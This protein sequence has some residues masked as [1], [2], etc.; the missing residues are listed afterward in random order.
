[1]QKAPDCDMALIHD[2]DLE[3]IDGIGKD[4]EWRFDCWS[5]CSPHMTT[6]VPGDPPTQHGNGPPLEFQHRD[7]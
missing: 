5:Y 7:T 1:M 6:V 3:K 4:C 2:D